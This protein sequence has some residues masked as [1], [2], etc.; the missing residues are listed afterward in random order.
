MIAHVAEA[1]E[2]SGRVLLWLEPEA[3]S[4]P[5]TFS[6][7][8][9]VAQA[10][11]AALET[12]VIDGPAP[13]SVEGLPSAQVSHLGR[14][15]KPSQDLASMPD[16]R[17]LLAERQ[18]REVGEIAARANVAICHASAGGDAIDR[19]AEMCLERGPWNIVAVAR[20]PSADLLAILSSILA[21]V[22]GATGVVVAG[23]RAASLTADVAVVVEDAER[24]PSMLRAAERL[25]GSGGR[26]HVMIAAETAATYAELDHQV[27]LVTAGM[28][29]CILHPGG[30]DF[31]VTGSCDETLF[32]LRACFVIARFG[33]TLLGDARALTRLLSVSPAPF[34]LVR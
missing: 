1:S 6:A 12:V 5:Q 15:T 3:V 11:S 16:A 17:A 31:G 19:L 30:A 7:S 26:I 13:S 4:M 34:L 2:A 21:N 18:R 14:L 20:P 10:Y 33:G 27:R 8:V 23:R 22:S 29:K 28:P 32:R 25:A 9:R 24:M